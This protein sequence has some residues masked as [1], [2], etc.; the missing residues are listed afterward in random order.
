MTTKYPTLFSVLSW[1]C[2]TYLLHN[3][4]EMPQGSS[5]TA[6]RCG[7]QRSQKDGGCCIDLNSCICMKETRNV[8]KIYEITPP[9]INKIFVPARHIM[10][11]FYVCIPI[12]RSDN[13][14]EQ[15]RILIHNYGSMDSVKAYP[16]IV[17][18]NIV[19]SLSIIGV[20]TCILHSSYCLSFVCIV[21]YRCRLRPK[22][23]SNTQVICINECQQY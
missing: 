7:L 22:I 2:Q 21:N 10:D 8:W 14:R 4:K 19:A 13:K 9:H 12:T 16:H 23:A 3:R 1:L 20:C 15:R 5:L 6:E 18:V 17:R 11:N